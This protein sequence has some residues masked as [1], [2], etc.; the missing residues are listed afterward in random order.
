MV[1]CEQSEKRMTVA[2][3]VASPQVTHGLYYS[4]KR[5]RLSIPSEHLVNMGLN[6]Y[7]SFINDGAFAV[8]WAEQLLPGDVGAEGTHGTCDDQQKKLS[9]FA[10]KKLSGNGMHMSHVLPIL[11]FT[12]S[13]CE[14][15]S[16]SGTAGGA[17]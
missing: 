17:T 16:R 8:P 14:L 11:L 5:N 2:S 6:V 1:D 15:W 7:P 4:V 10:I 9:T 13:L 12:L 3:K